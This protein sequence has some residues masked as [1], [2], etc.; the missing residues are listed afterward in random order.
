[1][2]TVKHTPALGCAYEAPTFGAHYPDGTCI[3]G[4][5][6]DLDSCDEPGGSLFTGGDMPCPW[7]NT[8]EHVEWRDQRFS[9]S[10]RQRRKAR[11][12][13]L[14]AVRAWAEARSSFPVAA[15]KANGSA[16]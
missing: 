15:S 12:A 11:R 3:D 2:S 13:S 9:G 10:A 6:W 5:M 4:Y 8:E 14:G 16:S 1:M 7:C